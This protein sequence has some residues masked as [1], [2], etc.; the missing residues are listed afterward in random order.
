M[1]SISPFITYETLHC[2]HL[3]KRKD[4]STSNP[5]NNGF[6]YGVSK[7]N[8]GFAR[9]IKLRIRHV[10]GQEGCCCGLIWAPQEGLPCVF[11]VC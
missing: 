8:A 7:K 6:K 4:E 5:Q 3:H 11:L 2:V 9:V 10:I 1:P